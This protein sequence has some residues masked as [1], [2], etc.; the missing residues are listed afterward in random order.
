MQSFLLK[1]N[2]KIVFIGDSITDCHRREEAHAPYGIGYVAMARDALIA[3]YPECNF[4]FENRG[5][6]GNTVRELRARWRDDVIAEGP[7]VLSVMIGVNDVFRTLRANPGEAVPLDEYEATYRGLLAEARDKTGA[8][9]VLAD[10]F[11]IEPDRKDPHRA[12]VDAYITCVHKLA[13]EFDAVSVRTQE[14]FD[15]AL[16]GQ[17][18]E[19][20][21]DDRVH[22]QSFGHAVIA[23]AWLKAVG[24]E[25]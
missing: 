15:E 24:Y 9:L 6:G 19:F 25:F 12:M 18:S 21:S 16:E 8:Q 3:R 2:Q 22:P 13:E 17:P 14:A 5:I 4:R 7:D 10:P 1:P 23:R 20:W 11:L